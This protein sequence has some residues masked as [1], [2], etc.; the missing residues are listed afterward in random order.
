MLDFL[1]ALGGPFKILLETG[2]GLISKSP[3]HN[4]DSNSTSSH[5]WLNKQA[6]AQFEYDKSI[7]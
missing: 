2:P 3:E 7:Y 6:G 4:L 1:F 5:T